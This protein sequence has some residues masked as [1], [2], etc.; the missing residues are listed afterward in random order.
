LNPRAGRAAIEIHAAVVGREAAL[1][2][3]RKDLLA[4]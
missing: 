2:A 3:S 1:T 4:V